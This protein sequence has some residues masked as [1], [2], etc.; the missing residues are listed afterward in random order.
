MSEIII[1]KLGLI[2]HPEGGYFKEVYR[3]DLKIDCDKTHGGERSA[4]TTIYYLLKN[5][6]FSAWHKLASD[7]TW[8]F[9]RGC[10][11]LLYTLD[12]NGR[13][14]THEIGFESYCF[15]LT[16]KANTWFCAK[17]KDESSYVLVSCSVAPGFDFADFHL[18]TAKELLEKFPQ[19]SAIIR[20][21]T[22]N[23]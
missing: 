1:Q 22:R 13:L 5:K 21:F 20:A 11:L 9:H 6:D 8:Y 18:A 7:E 14:C 23:V 16:V 4:Y 2:P 10:D 3:A 12:Q 15:Q 19:H 17:P